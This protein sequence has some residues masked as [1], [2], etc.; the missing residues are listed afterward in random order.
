LSTIQMM[1]E[2]WYNLIIIDII[3]ID[4]MICS[5]SY[6]FELNKLIDWS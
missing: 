1:H 4:V 3:F 2:I 5:N 6:E